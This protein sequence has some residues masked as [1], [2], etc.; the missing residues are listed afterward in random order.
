MQIV[1]RSPLPVNI[2]YLL[3]VFDWYANARLFIRLFHSIRGYQQLVALLHI[4]RGGSA[5]GQL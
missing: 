4:A 5:H 1:C 2:K 3:S